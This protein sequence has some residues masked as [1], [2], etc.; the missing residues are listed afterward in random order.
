MI[1][2]SSA[3]IAILRRE[4]D[5]AIYSKAIEQAG[6]KL[7]AAPTFLE[8]S[9]V[10]I[11]RKGT[12]ASAGLDSFLFRSG[13]EIISFTAAVAGVAVDAF[14]RYGKG[15]H[16]AGLNFGDCISYAMAKTELM[17]LLF[18]GD[19]FRLTDIEAAL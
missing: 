2:D 7:M 15:R 3:V 17:P 1:V 8:A 11:G 16:P 9:I 19:D 6:R 14:I 4:S 13:I 18:K 5:A 10:I 12:A